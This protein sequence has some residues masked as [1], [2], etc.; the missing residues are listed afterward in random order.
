VVGELAA[1]QRNI[2]PF[3]HLFFFIRKSERRRPIMLLAKCAMNHR[4]LTR[5]RPYAR[6]V[7]G[8]VVQKMEQERVYVHACM[9]AERARPG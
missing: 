4:T 3:R 2:D 8:V 6:H 9:C 5:S 7:C 1:G